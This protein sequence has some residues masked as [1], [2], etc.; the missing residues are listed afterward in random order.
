[1]RMVIP[2]GEIRPPWIIDED[3]L[4]ASGVTLVRRGAHATESLRRAMLRNGITTVRVRLGEEAGKPIKPPIPADLALQA[5]RGVQKLIIRTMRDRTIS[6]NLLSYLIAQMS[7]VVEALFSGESPV[8][9]ELHS[10]SDHDAYTY[11]H[12]WSV[13][14]FSLVLGRVAMEAGVMKRLDYTDRLNLGIGAVLHDIGKTLISPSILNKP[15]PLNDDE[16]KIMRRHPQDGFDLLRPY[17]SLMPMVRAI[18]A[19]HHE[20]LDG[21][22][23]GL[24][25]G[26][27]LPGERIPMS[28]RIV[29][30]A[31]AYDAMISTRPYKR[32]RLPF[33]ALEILQERA[34]DQFD[35]G[36]APLMEQVVIPFPEGALL[37]MRDGAV[38][39]VLSDGG[40]GSRHPRPVCLVVGTFD[41]GSRMRPGQTF[42]LEERETVLLGAATP[43][44][45][46]TSTM[47]EGRGKLVIHSAIP[48]WDDLFAAALERADIGSLEP[49]NAG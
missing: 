17:T 10:L 29:T 5:R 1:M 37:L 25:D 19:F 22:G 49:P 7:V 11:E 38:A 34:G 30:V 33:E 39:S 15:G 24:V 6:S 36:L 44:E 13:A 4:S 40:L 21:K 3:I 23:Y 14:L 9:S 27:T 31:D 35:P 46:V 32:G 42:V 43:D 8:F 20:R 18:V 45:I 28:V 26:N 41:R 48:P 2:V 12:S 47:R 16:W